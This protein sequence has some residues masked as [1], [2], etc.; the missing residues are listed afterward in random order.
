MADW[1][2]Q[3]KRLN[4]KHVV[5]FAAMPHVEGSSEGKLRDRVLPSSPEL[6]TEEAVISLVRAILGDGGRITVVAPAPLAFLA[7]VVAGE[8]ATPRLDE[9]PE[10]RQRAV[11]VVV[12][13]GDDAFAHLDRIGYV[14]VNVNDQMTALLANSNNADALVCIGDVSTE[15]VATFQKHNDSVTP[16]FAFAATGQLAARLT[17]SGVKTIVADRM[18][19]SEA[20]LPRRDPDSRDDFADEFESPLPALPLAA[21]WIVERI[22]QGEPRRRRA[23]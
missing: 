13:E 15:N 8:F 9:N 1:S 18:V 6:E 21:Q 17:D 2:P 14:A 11:T 10:T 20:P 16:V 3:R 19:E 22:I 12:D 23:E 7:S 4:G 5:L